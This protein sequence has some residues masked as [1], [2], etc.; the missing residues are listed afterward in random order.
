MHASSWARQCLWHM[1]EMQLSKHV[2]PLWLPDLQDC[3]AGKRYFQH[4]KLGDI[5]DAYPY[6]S[7]LSDTDL[8]EQ[9]NAREAFLDFLWGI[10]VRSCPHAWPMCHAC[11]SL[12]DSA[13]AAATCSSGG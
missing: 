13:G 1:A 4:T 5:I 2:I 11:I 9:R 6:K 12:E 8:T 7:G 10:L 3:A